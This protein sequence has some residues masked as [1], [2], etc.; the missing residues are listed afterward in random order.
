MAH[1]K[2]GVMRSWHLFAFFFC[3]FIQIFRNGGRVLNII[4]HHKSGTVASFNI[5]AFLC[6]HGGME[7]LFRRYNISSDMDLWAAY[8]KLSHKCPD[9][10]I[11]DHGVPGYTVRSGQA[12]VHMVRNPIDMLLSGYLYHRGCN[13]PDTTNSSETNRGYR[14]YTF[15][16]RP[17]PLHSSYCL[18]LQQNDEPTGMALELQRTMQAFDGIGRM[19]FDYRML[20]DYPLKLSV[21]SGN[22]IDYKYAIEE[23]TRPWN[24]HNNTFEVLDISSHRSDD[25][26]KARL[27]RTAVHV[28]SQRIP[29]HILTSAFRCGAEHYY[30]TGDEFEK[31]MKSL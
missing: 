16:S 25:A 23:F 21:C 19:F 10:V 4:T 14:D 20:T 5:W 12:Y 27:Y 1:C 3:C 22:M 26:E 9:I 2:L 7:T 11:H 28:A 8:S 15:F 18:W 24:R 13:E 29:L 17:W 6:I 30:Q 31:L